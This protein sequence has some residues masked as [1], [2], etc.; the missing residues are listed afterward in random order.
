MMDEY[1]ISCFYVDVITYPWPNLNTGSV[2][3]SY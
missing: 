2:N 1:D 3:L